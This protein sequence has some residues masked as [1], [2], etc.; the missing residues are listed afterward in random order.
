MNGRV[1]KGASHVTPFIG[2]LRAVSMRD[3]LSL[4][5]AREQE[6]RRS[7]RATLRFPFLNVLAIPRVPCCSKLSVCGTTKASTG[8]Y[9]WANM[10]AKAFEIRRRR[11]ER[12]Q[13]MTNLSFARRPPPPLSSS[14]VKG[15]GERR[16]RIAVARYLH[17]SAVNLIYS[18]PIGSTPCRINF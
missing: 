7:R 17:R 16:R 15:L 11:L 18:S 4:N 12:K 1:G 3:T 13:S 9:E 5:N 6:R 8:S 2:C 10:R 14:I